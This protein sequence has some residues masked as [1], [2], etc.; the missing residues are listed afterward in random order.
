MS[1]EWEGELPALASLSS[2]AAADSINAMTGPSI[3]GEIPKMSF[4]PL[5]AAAI[6]RVYA[7]GFTGSVVYWTAILQLWTSL[8]SVH[9]ANPDTQAVIGRAETDGVLL[10]AE[11]TDL[12]GAITS[13]PPK[14]V[15][16]ATPG[17]VN[18]ARGRLA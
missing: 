13:V 3:V 10:P 14:Y 7:P 18:E 8:D 16:Q 6:G 11:V 9:P 4:A 12:V 2:E 5:L 17:E 15:T 1:Y